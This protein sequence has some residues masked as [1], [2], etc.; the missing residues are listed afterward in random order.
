MA[1]IQVLQRELDKAK[2]AGGDGKMVRS[3]FMIC[4]SMWKDLLTNVEVAGF[5]AGTHQS[6]ARE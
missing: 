4:Y 2:K 3:N 5:T 6:A 1:H